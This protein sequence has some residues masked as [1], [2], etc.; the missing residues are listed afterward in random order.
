MDCKTLFDYA[1]VFTGALKNAFSCVNTDT[2]RDLID[3]FMECL[4]RM[5]LMCI[6]DVKDEII[7]KCSWKEFAT[8]ISW[9][10]GKKLL[11]VCT[12]FHFVCRFVE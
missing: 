6:L 7:V 9:V 4:T 2:C 12:I 8:F 3:V 11:Y 5:Y 1:R 10:R